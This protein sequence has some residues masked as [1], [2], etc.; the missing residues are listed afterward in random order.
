M[1][2]DSMCFC[3]RA[4]IIPPPHDGLPL[5]DQPIENKQEIKP[6]NEALPDAV[7]SASDQKDSKEQTQTSPKQKQPCSFFHKNCF[8]HI[9]IYLFLFLVPAGLACLTLVPSQINAPKTLVIPH[10][11]SVQEIGQ[12]LETNK[13]VI[14]ALLFRGVARVVA[15]NNLQAGEYQFSPDQS[16]IDL[17]MMMHDGRSIIRRFTVPEGLTTH[18]ILKMIEEDLAL[19]GK[20]TLHPEEG[21]LLPETYHYSY[22]DQRNA[23]IERMQKAAREELN[24]LWAT[25]AP[26][27]PLKTPEEALV[28]ASIVERETG[29]KAEERPRVAGVFYNRLKIGM[30]LQSDPTVIYALTNGNTALTRDLTH[31]D[32]DIA[33]PYNTYVNA[34]LPPKPICNP[35]RAS[36]LAVLHPETHDYLYFVADGTGGHAFAKDLETHNKNV[37]RWLNGDHP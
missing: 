25:R 6:P 16:L 26:N 37:A 17:I 14:N 27:L 5:N 7:E 8:L 10:G 30:R 22:G 15:G 35:G 28:M 31:E 11:T 34:G 12:M 23:L 19:S 18:E 29:K 2:I 20:T 21:T 24:A 9:F 4:K 3:T 33:S 32:L 13:I 36:L 1:V